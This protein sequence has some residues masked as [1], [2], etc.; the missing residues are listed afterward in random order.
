M[1][2]RYVG[3]VRALPLCN[4]R[5]R[6]IARISINHGHLAKRTVAAAEH[7]NATVLLIQ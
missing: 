5:A 7:V 1:F 4:N 2:Q 3:T 6:Q